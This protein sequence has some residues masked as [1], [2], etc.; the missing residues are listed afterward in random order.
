[1]FSVMENITFLIFAFTLSC[2]E[3]EMSEMVNRMNKLL[4][5]VCLV[6]VSAISC[7]QKP[8]TGIDEDEPVPGQMTM[9]VG[10]QKKDSVENDS[11]VIAWTIGIAVQQHE[12]DESCNI[13]TRRSFG[14][15]VQDGKER[16]EWDKGDKIS[17]LLYPESGLSRIDDYM[18]DTTTILNDGRYSYAEFF[19]SDNYINQLSEGIYRFYAKYP[20]GSINVSE[21]G[22]Y[23]TISGYIPETQTGVFNMDYAYMYAMKADMLGEGSNPKRLDL[24]FE[25]MFTV[26]EFTVSA[27]D[28][29]VISNVTLSSASGNLSGSFDARFSNDSSTP[30]YIFSSDSSAK[31]MKVDLSGLS[32]KDVSRNKCVTFTVLVPPN[33]I[34]GLTL[35]FELEGGLGTRVISFKDAYETDYT[36]TGGMKHKISCLVLRRWIDSLALNDETGTYQPFTE[37]PYIDFAVDTETGFGDGE[38]EGNQIEFPI[39]SYNINL[40]LLNNIDANEE[41]IEVFHEAS[42]AGESIYFYLRYYVEPNQWYYWLHLE[43]L[44]PNQLYNQQQYLLKNEVTFNPPTDHRRKYQLK[45]PITS[46]MV[47]RMLR[48]NGTTYHEGLFHIR[49][50]NITLEGAYITIENF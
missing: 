17:I 1:M 8:E 46:Q 29:M 36:F 44:G 34:T 9:I 6:F 47:D 5:L 7:T 27:D 26:L 28:N 18:I 39:A 12:L 38:Y 20:S 32:S 41:H 11:G 31:E 45:I 3:P 10:H 24:G 19:P 2:I 25:P 43:L 16:I 42:E 21:S 4:V 49:G 14:N 37:K 48:E 13:L 22:Q 35:K 30:E 33:D 15:N 23:A 50:G 40:P